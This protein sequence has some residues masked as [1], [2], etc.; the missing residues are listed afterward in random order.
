MNKNI[1]KLISSFILFY[2]VAFLLLYVYRLLF[3]EGDIFLLD[4]F[5]KSYD[6][7]VTLQQFLKFIPTIQI[8]A[9]TIIF[10]WLFSVICEKSGLGARDGIFSVLRQVLIISILLTCITMCIQEI[11]LPQ[12]QWKTDT[13]TR[14]SHDFLNYKN[15]AKEAF[16]KNDLAIA[17]RAARDAMIISPTDNEILELSDKIQNKIMEEKRKIPETKTLNVATTTPSRENV[18]YEVFFIKAKKLFS[19]E[20]YFEAHHYAT[21]AINGFPES[22]KSHKECQTIIEDSWKMLNRFNFSLADNSAEIFAEKRRGFVALEKGNFVDSY[23]IFKNLQKT[24]PLDPDVNRMLHRTEAGLRQNYFFTDEVNRVTSARIIGNVYF[25]TKKSNGNSVLVKI[26]GI[27][28]MNDTSGSVISF[29]Q[30]VSI[31]EFTGSGQPILSFEVE[32]AK[33]VSLNPAKPDDSLPRLLIN[34]ID[35]E[36]EGLGTSPVFHIKPDNFA[37]NSFYEFP[38]SFKDLDMIDTAFMGPDAMSLPDL[39]R[40]VMGDNYY[41]YSF[42]IYFANLIERI[43]MPFF[44][45]FMSLIAAIVAWK[46]RVKE[47]LASIKTTWIFFIPVII[48]LMHCFLG[49]FLYIFHVLIYITIGIF[50]KVAFFIILAILFVLISIATVR[51]T[52]VCRK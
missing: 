16:R 39:I 27:T 22:N 24:L 36:V 49:V 17:D 29:L 18:S 11:F 2:I 1:G 45:V 52:A 51:F 5:T 34:S 7:Y 43:C 41:G 23:Y 50:S 26:G 31:I 12:F 3:P 6:F 42:E 38:I 21:M 15:E 46:Y 44:M 10:S 32:R 14:L 8:S 28:G 4:E 47:V 40:F 19:E 30:D 13:M 35:P 25:S 20:K 37:K 9:I 48:M 33:L